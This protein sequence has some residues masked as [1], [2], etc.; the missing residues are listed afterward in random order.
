MSEQELQTLIEFKQIKQIVVQ[1]LEKYEQARNNDWILI[2]LVL[3]EIAKQDPELK[4]YWPNFIPFSL[5]QKLPAAETI[6]RI[7]RKLQEKGQFLPTDPKVMRK[8]ERRRE[9]IRKVIHE[10]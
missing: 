8:R 3:R 2:H 10:V 4:K 1:I 9:A 5:L 6:T 7:R